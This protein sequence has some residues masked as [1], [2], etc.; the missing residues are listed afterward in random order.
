[1]GF[2]GCSWDFVGT[3]VNYVKAETGVE[4]AL[5]EGLDEIPAFVGATEVHEALQTG[6][7]QS[8]GYGVVDSGCGRTLIGRK[9]P[10]PGQRKEVRRKGKEE[11]R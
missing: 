4:Y 9:P 2:Q 11:V 6:L 1:M 7:V 8:P 3:A 10:L 5:Q